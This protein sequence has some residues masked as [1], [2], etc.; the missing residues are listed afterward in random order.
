[1]GSVRT[2]GGRPQAIGRG[3]MAL[4]A[5]FLLVAVAVRLTSGRPITLTVGEQATTDA[6]VVT[7][8]GWERDG[9]D[10]LATISA[11]RG[12]TGRIVDL[13]AFR[14]VTPEG[15]ETEPSG[16]RLGPA[17]VGPECVEGSLPFASTV[18]PDRIVYRASP[19]VIW[20]PA[21]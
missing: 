7:V 10:I 15:D 6:G 1:M 20:K 19:L 14:L 9:D 21:A 5:A 11:C 12:E 17:E 4:A 18:D 8:H 3:L 16:S 2:N 13:G